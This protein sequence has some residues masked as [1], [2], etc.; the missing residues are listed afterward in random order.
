MFLVPYIRVFVSSV[1]GIDLDVNKYCW[2]EWFAACLHIIT[3]HY[4]FRFFSSSGMV[5]RGMVQSHIVITSHYFPVIRTMLYLKCILLTYNSVSSLFLLHR[6][7]V[8]SILN[9]ILCIILIFYKVLSQF[10]YNVR[11]SCVISRCKLLIRYYFSLFYGHRNHIISQ[12]H[13]TLFPVYFCC[14][15]SM[16]L[17]Y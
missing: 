3:S 9:H 1:C 15:A 16:S 11:I 2:S 6:V 4:H 14:I 5:I 8:P 13:I 10:W 17:P 12:I 7:Y